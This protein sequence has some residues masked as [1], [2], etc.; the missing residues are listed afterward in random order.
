[1]AYTKTVT[2]SV[3]VAGLHTLTLSDVD[4]LY[5]GD[6]I[7]VSGCNNT[8]DGNHDITAI[9]TTNK[10]VSFVNGNHTHAEETENGQLI[11]L[12]EWTTD[13]DVQ[14]W[15]GIAAATANDTAFI[16]QCVESANEWC[17]RRR[18]QSGYNDRAALVPS[19]A[20]KLGT[21]MYAA[22]AYRER[23][24]VDGFA[25]F[26]TMAAGGVPSMSLGR[27]MQLLGVN[28]AQVA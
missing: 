15:L 23:G 11:V 4:D 10:T 9:N 18:Q 14:S 25:S 19:P 12:V 13:A 6:R 16:A 20:V 24:A 5:V 21:T 7:R 22:I 27:V 8:F 17:F 26:E 28:R 2:K 3:A 1:M